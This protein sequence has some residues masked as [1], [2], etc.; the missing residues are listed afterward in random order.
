MG[1]VGADGV[2]AGGGEVFHAEGGI[3]ARSLWGEVRDGGFGEQG[4]VGGCDGEGLGLG[5]E[6]VRECSAEGRIR[7]DW[8]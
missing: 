1:S 8:R 3:F 6:S 2:G 7:Q 4:E 5:I